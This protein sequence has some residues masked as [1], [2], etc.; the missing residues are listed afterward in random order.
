MDRA[1]LLT[2]PRKAIQ[3]LAKEHGINAG[4]KTVDMI[5][6][7]CT[8]VV[9]RTRSPF[10]KQDALDEPVVFPVDEA[11]L[12]THGVRGWETW[13]SEPMIEV[14]ENESDEDV[15]FE[16][17]EAVVTPISDDGVRGKP[18]IIKAGDFAVIPGGLEGTWEWDIKVA[19]HKHYREHE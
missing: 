11:F 4:Q 19:V 2:M 9:P 7:L 18:V 12:V 15:W 13:D 16:T 1:E 5:D 14:F 6:A 8:P 17:G 10:L 3:A